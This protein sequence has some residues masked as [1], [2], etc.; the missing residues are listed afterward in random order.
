MFLRKS[1]RG[2][3]HEHAFVGNVVMKSL[4]WS[5]CSKDSFGHI[6]TTSWVCR[7]AGCAHDKH[8]ANR[9]LYI[10]FGSVVTEFHWI[11]NLLPNMGISTRYYLYLFLASHEQDFVWKMAKTWRWP[12]FFKLRPQEAPRPVLVLQG[13]SFDGV[14]SLNQTRWGW[15]LSTKTVFFFCCMGLYYP[16]TKEI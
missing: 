14:A 16:G 2:K 13:H 10:I 11:S 12:R 7:C 6:A 4:K 8:P 3:S 9:T 5:R 1:P 15:H